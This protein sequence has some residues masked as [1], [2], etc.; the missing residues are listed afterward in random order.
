M[1]EARTFLLVLQPCSNK[2]RL[3]L[4]IWFYCENFLQPHIGLFPFLLKVCLSE[5]WNVQVRIKITHHTASNRHWRN[6]K[7]AKTVFH[8]S[9][10]DLLIFDL[11]FA[12]PDYGGL[13][14]PFRSVSRGSS[15]GTPVHDDALL[16]FVGAQLWA[17]SQPAVVN[18][19]LQFKMPN[20]KAFEVN[21]VVVG[22]R[23]DSCMAASVLVVVVGLKSG[24]N[25][26]FYSL[27]QT[28]FNFRGVADWLSVGC[29]RMKWRKFKVN[30]EGPS[31][32][33]CTVCR[34]DAILL[35]SPT[36][37]HNPPA[38][39]VNNMAKR[40]SKHCLKPRNT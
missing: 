16:L 10:E 4:S 8:L 22:G 19:G 39:T 1:L 36:Q 37:T 34:L 14:R 20:N 15:S 12:T 18:C 32:K 40:N 29:E 25:V 38:Y 13:P 35:L 28:K 26:I 21:V 5:E 33:I 7:N 3:F 31:E 2:R 24:A 9:V 17:A 6:R 11:L 23:S 30:D 27:W